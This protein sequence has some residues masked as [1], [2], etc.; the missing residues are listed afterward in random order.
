MNIAHV[1][2]DHFA[3]EVLESPDPVLV[4][5][6]APWCGPCRVMNG[7][8]EE[9][10]AERP[11]LRIRKVNSDEQPELSARYGVMG[12]PTLLVFNGGEPVQ[13]LV[14]ARPKRKL[15]SELAV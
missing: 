1:D 3:A 2:S 9:V 11:D 4:D 14:G 5:F 8:L 13:Q 6:W 12:I 10:A 7:V 15:L